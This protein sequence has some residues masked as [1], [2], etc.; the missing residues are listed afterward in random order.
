VKAGSINLQKLFEQTI[1]YRIPLF[2]RPYVWTEKENWRPIWD[3]LRTLAERLVRTGS[4]SPHFLGAIVLDQ[5]LNQTGEIES[6]QVIDGQQRLTTLQLMLTAFRDLAAANGLEK[7]A[8]RFEKLTS[9]DESF[10]VNEDDC[11]KVWPTN[12]DRAH[13]RKVMSS[14]TLESVC[15]T[16]KIN[17]DAK[18]LDI[19]IPGAYIYF[20]R[21]VAEWLTKELIDHCGIAIDVSIEDRMDAIWTVVRSHLLLVAIDL[22]DA[23]DAQVIFETLNARGTQLLPADLVKNFLFQM[24]ES[25]GADL[26][27]LYAKHWKG[28]DADFW[29]EEIRQGR[30]KRPRIDLF[31]Q[32]Y[33]TLKTSDEVPV[34]HVFA[35]FKTHVEQSIHLSPAKDHPNGP[36][37]YHL[38][39][40]KTY[41]KIFKQ[42]LST[43]PESRLG[44]FFERLAAIDTATVYPL[45]LE[46]FHDLYEPNTRGELRRLVRDIESFLVRRM[47]CGLT[48]KNYN[49]FFLDMIRAC[50]RDGRISADAGR[51]FLSKADGDS[52]RWPNN[53]EMREAMLE[54][55][56]Y[57]K[58][59][60]KKL[61]MLLLA[62]ERQ[63]EDGKTEPVI[64]TDADNFTIEHVMPQA[65]SKHWPLPFD[66]YPDD[67]E[68]SLTNWRESYIHTIGN[69]TLLTKKLNPALSARGWEYKQANILASSK[70][71]LNRYFADIED[72][73]EDWIYERSTEL[74]KLAVRIWPYPRANVSGEVVAEE[75]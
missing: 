52:V 19:K 56:L 24:A 27:E 67:D 45:L 11:F 70:M 10:C 32:H 61:R 31:L 42:F 3:D 69:L 13:F 21:S 64:Y 44:I 5:V 7:I 57:R 1:R 40:L 23:D 17:A 59:S 71:N 2:Q 43:D 22:E 34:T 30:L 12:R 16:F 29:R 49:R 37:A 55:P 66:A 53:K 20:Y 74:T 60:Q 51:E 63:L 41:G 8:K 26:D 75:Q 35:Y 46:A 28:F 47:I 36:A 48:T 15:K 18:T 38:E 58:L 14:G 72:W 4:T 25:E 73:N 68:A 54:L 33:L 39:Q 62:F 50:R 9:N 6:R 65:W